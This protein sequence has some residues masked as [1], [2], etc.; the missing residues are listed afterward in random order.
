M[1]TDSNAK[2]LLFTGLGNIREGTE[3]DTII[4]KFSIY[5]CSDTRV[6]PRLA[7]CGG[8]FVAFGLYEGNS[9]SGYCGW[10]FMNL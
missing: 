1:I 5:R 4:T 9:S 7:I 3:P 8:Y 6:C 2:R 10:C